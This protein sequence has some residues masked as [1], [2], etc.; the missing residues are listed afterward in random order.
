MRNR[1]RDRRLELNG[2]SKEDFM[3]FIEEFHR[4]GKIV[5]ELN[6]TFIALIPKRAIPDSLSDYRPISLVGSMYKILA[7]V[8]ANHLKKVIDTVIREEQMTFISNR[9]I[10]YSF[11]IAE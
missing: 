5:K 4:D 9:Q 6:N 2:F 11:I 8:L 1:R 7:K 10:L 3:K